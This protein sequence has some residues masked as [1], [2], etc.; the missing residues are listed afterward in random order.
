MIFVALSCRFCGCTEDRPC[1]NR[2]GET[3]SW[4]S[5]NV[6]TFCALQRLPE[7]TVRLI[8]FS[9]TAHRL[10]GALPTWPPEVQATIAHEY[11]ARIDH[12][13]P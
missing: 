3:C 9:L 11:A 2:Y 13:Q 5:V 12:T 8:A 10:A 1:V 6:C 4:L 7:E